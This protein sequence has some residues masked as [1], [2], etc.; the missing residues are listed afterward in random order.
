MDFIIRPLRNGL[1]AQ[2]SLVIS[3]DGK[4]LFWANIYSFSNLIHLAESTRKSILKDISLFYSHA[5]ELNYE[6]D[7]ILANGEINTLIEL[8]ESFFIKLFNNPNNSAVNSINRWRNLRSFIE[9]T[10][11]RLTPSF[12]QSKGE[13]D[14]IDDKLNRLHRLYAQLNYRQK[15]KK[16]P[17]RALSENAVNTLFEIIEPDSTHN[18]FRKSDQVRNFLLVTFMLLLGL[19]T[20]ECLILTTKNIGFE[21]DRA[22]LRITSTDESLKDERST[23]PSIKTEYSHRLVPLPDYLYALMNEYLSI[24]RKASSNSTFIFTSNQGKPLSSRQVRYILERIGSAM[25]SHFEGVLS[26][27]FR[28]PSLSPHD[29]RHTAACSLLSTFHKESNDMEKSLNQLRE[30]M[31][32]S[33]SSDMPMRYARLYLHDEANSA[34]IKALDKRLSLFCGEKA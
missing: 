17:H 29:L 33:P 18:P 31:G 13:I 11:Y 9:S 20:S 14:D 8:S 25:E 19:R 6:L 16:L 21:N 15:T 1:P 23:V 30:F 34:S 7:E 28:N 12:K 2:N 26:E 27:N 3:S 22:W 10:V 32:W 5:F 4:L 24:S